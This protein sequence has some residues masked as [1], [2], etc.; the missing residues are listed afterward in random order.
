MPAYLN[1]SHLRPWPYHF[2]AWPIQTLLLSA[3]TPGPVLKL[4][5]PDD[6]QVRVHSE[7]VGRTPSL[8]SVIC[9]LNP[10]LCV[11]LPER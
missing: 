2:D 1:T 8:I 7:G 4:A 10:W 5:L 11:D 9:I 6:D 3:H